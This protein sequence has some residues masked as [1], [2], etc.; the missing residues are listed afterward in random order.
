MNDSSSSGDGLSEKD[1]RGLISDHHR[2]FRDPS[3]LFPIC[4]R[5]LGMSKERFDQIIKMIKRG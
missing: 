5:V 3:A 4:S 2:R 1:I